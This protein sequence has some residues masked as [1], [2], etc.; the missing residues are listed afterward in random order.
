M[1]GHTSKIVLVTGAGGSI[2]SELVRQIARDI[3]SQLLLVDNCELSLFNIYNELSNDPFLKEVSI[4]ALLL[5]CTR[6]YFIEYFS[7]KSIDF[8]YHVAAYKHVNLSEKNPLSYYHNNIIATYF[9]QKL[10]I[11][12]GANFVLVST[13]KAVNPLNVMG[14]SKRLSE[15]LVL[16]NANINDSFSKNSIVRFGNVLNSS[17]SV[18]PIF[19][20]QIDKGGPVTVTDKD[21][22]RYFMSISEATSLI[23]NSVKIQSK[24]GIFVLDM[25]P[26]I[27]IN[28]LACN[29]I[30]QAGY[31]VTFN[32]ANV[33]EIKIEYI[34]LRPGEKKEEV[35]SYGDLVNSEVSRIKVANE[36]IDFSESEKEVCL[37]FAKGNISELPEGFSWDNGYG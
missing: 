30:E 37:E 7:E 24:L 32:N 28:T 22:T 14:K 29:L 13:D 36:R 6:S 34:G 18:I 5:D 9:C 4:N 2:G 27:N 15:I 11:M 20:S 31:K 17:G 12:L 26:V 23:V 3:P 19:K 10:S 1:G 8:I 21:A 35:L 16:A 33:G 25:G